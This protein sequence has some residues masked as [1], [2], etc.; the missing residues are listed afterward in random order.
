MKVIMYW[1]SSLVLARRLISCL[2]LDQELSWGEKAIRVIQQTWFQHPG[3]QVWSSPGFLIG[4][5]TIPY[6]CQW[7]LQCF[8]YIIY[9]IVCRWYQCLCHREKSIKF[10]YNNEY[11]TCQIVGVDECHKLSL[12]V[13]KAQVYVIL[14]QKLQCDIKWYS[15]ELWNYRKS[16]AL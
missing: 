12:T 13:K 9:I 7:S 11:W 1:A 5:T 15:I 3:H 16:G 8:I 6:I 10:I 2:W 14:H 4:T